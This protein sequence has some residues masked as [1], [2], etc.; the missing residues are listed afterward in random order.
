MV[1]FRAHLRLWVVVGCV[2]PVAPLMALL[3]LD[4]CTAHRSDSRVAAYD[5]ESAHAPD[6]TTCPMHQPTQANDED[7]QMRSGCTVPVDVI[8]ALL[9]HQGI[10]SESLAMPRSLDSRPAPVL[11]S[12]VVIS[13]RLLPD[14]PPP[15]V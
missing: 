1:R 7:C 8:A 3:P 14:T 10:L 15:R 4:C 2:F 9:G 13:L 11:G 6:P 12:E 5:R